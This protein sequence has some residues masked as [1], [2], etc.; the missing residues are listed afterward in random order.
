MAEDKEEGFYWHRNHKVDEWVER[1]M[2]ECVWDY[3]SEFYGVE[4][5]H[6]LTEEQIQEVEAFR[7]E[8]NEYS[9]LQW[10]FS[11]LCNTWESET[12]EMEQENEQDSE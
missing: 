5:V 1:E 3:V 10:G 4:E 9:P 7:N 8:L 2:I 12:W 11:W 6:E